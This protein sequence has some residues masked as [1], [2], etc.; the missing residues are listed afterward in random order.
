MK[1]KTPIV[2]LKEL[3]E[4]MGSYIS[5]VERGRSFLV[6]R[7]SK[8]IFAMSPVDEWGDEGKWDTIIDFRKINPHGVPIFDVIKALK[9]SLKKK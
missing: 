3:R 6:L 4:N 5:A 2:G 9:K 1:I 7:K 8:P